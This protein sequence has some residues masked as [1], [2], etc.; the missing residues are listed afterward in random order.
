MRLIVCLLVFECYLTISANPTLFRRANN[1]DSPSSE[2]SLAGPY[3]VVQESQN[4]STSS[5]ILDISSESTQ[6]TSIPSPSVEMSSNMT[7]TFHGP[8]RPSRVRNTNTTRNRFQ[9]KVLSAVARPGGNNLELVESLVLIS[10]IGPPSP[11]SIMLPAPL[12]ASTNASITIQAPK[13]FGGGAGRAGSRPTYC[14]CEPQNILPSFVSRRIFVSD[15]GS[16]P[17]G[18][19]GFFGMGSLSRSLSLDVG[20]TTGCDEGS[21]C[22]GNVCCTDPLERYRKSIFH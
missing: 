21:F 16:R 20:Y 12:L 17:V 14:P 22:V 6:Q 5:P 9:T 4:V 2:P 1:F 7:A 11:S 8:R 10:R 19:C 13:G 15:F 3:G 18:T